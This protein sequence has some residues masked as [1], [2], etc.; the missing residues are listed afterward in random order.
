MD[1]FPSLSL[2]IPSWHVKIWLPDPES[3]YYRGTRFDH[4]GVFASVRLFG[5]EFCA[6]WLEACDPFRHD[7]VQGPA[8]EFGV[9]GFDEAAPGET[10]LKIGVGLLR[11]PDDA[12]YD[13]FRLYEIADPG[14]RETVSD[15]HSVTM[16]HILDGYYDYTKIIQLGP[17]GEMRISHNLTAFV[18]LQSNVYNH[19]FFT[20]GSYSI[21][22]GREVLFP[23]PVDGAWREDYDS[24]YP[25]PGTSVAFRRTLKK[26]DSVFC[27]GIHAVQSDTSPY[28]L[29]I[30]HDGTGQ[31]VEVSSPTPFNR[32]NFW[33]NHR[34]ACIEPFVDF[35]LAPGETFTQDINYKLSI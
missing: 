26:G 2:G 20:L 8:E 11:R 32:A 19:N 33:A 22:S 25:M 17:L 6:P 34:V 5:K 13:H 27:G 12:P 31:V 10:F 18:P 28:R 29:V 3:G 24:I 30:R 15:K 21:R 23:Y 7:N 16:R 4:S 1:K 9:V 35:A 14:R